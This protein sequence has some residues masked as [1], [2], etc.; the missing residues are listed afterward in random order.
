MFCE[1]GFVL[2]R[3]QLLYINTFSTGGF[4]CRV[5]DVYVHF[6]LGSRLPASLHAAPT[7]WLH[8]GPVT[9][10]L[11]GVPGSILTAHPCSS[12]VFHVFSVQWR[13]VCP[14]PPSRPSLYFWPYFLPTFFQDFVPV[15]Y[16]LISVFP[17][18]GGPQAVSA[19]IGNRDCSLP[20]KDRD[21]P[22]HPAAEGLSSQPPLELRVAR[23][24]WAEAGWESWARLGR[25]AAVDVTA[26]YLR[27]RV[28][29]QS[30][31]IEGGI[32]GDAVKPL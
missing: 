22:A 30:Q 28:C 31:S 6:S 3:N 32:S 21:S 11:L 7:R 25:A 4:A 9:H 10:V 24:R 13:W 17:W 27:C 23:G 16:Y 15:N 26:A 20:V 2:P 1:S 8:K 14:P 18:C 29:I 12:L 19:G 5:S